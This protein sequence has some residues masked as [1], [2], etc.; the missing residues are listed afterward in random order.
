[1]GAPCQK[2]TYTSTEGKVLKGQAA[3]RAYQADLK[4]E[5]K[6]REQEAQKE[7]SRYHYHRA[8]HGTGETI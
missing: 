5:T 7:R 3:Y 6:Y 2:F 4:R 8:S 1:M